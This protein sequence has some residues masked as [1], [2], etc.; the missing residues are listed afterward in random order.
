MKVLKT[1]FWYIQYLAIRFGS[2]LYS[3]IPA[4]K[5]YDLGF[6]FAKLFYPVFKVRHR[7]AVD[8]IL[9]AGITD[10]PRR[11]AEIARTSFCHFAGH[12]CEALK[13]REVI[14]EKNWRDH[15]VI[16]GSK[17][18]TWD[19]LM[20][21]TDTPMMLITGH[22]GAWEAATTLI[23]FT[24]PMIAI[25][26]TMDNPF[27]T[28]FLQKNHFRGRI[29]VIEK[30][31][32][33]PPNVLRHWKAEKAALTLVMDQH[34]SDR[35]R[36][37]SNFMGRPAYTQSSAARIYLK[38]GYPILVGAFLRDGPFQYRM[39]GTKPMHLVPTG[40]KQKDIETFVDEMN[41][42]LEFLIRRYPEQYLWSHRRWRT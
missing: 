1:T 10:D 25:A 7:I 4:Y 19:L 22:Q 21:K 11:A 35:H 29:T 38:T 40:D 41:Q 8:N 5:A 16:E 20:E 12:L 32:G 27:L 39:L 6:G 13:V 28:R 31:A 30:N 17:E 23:P 9:Q 15:V 18:D 33:L 36:V 24:R 34:S 3:L 37:R 42:R 14:T 2:F 26:R